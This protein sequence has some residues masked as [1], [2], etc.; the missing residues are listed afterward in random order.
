MT[1]DKKAMLKEVYHDTVKIVGGIL[2]GLFL[3]LS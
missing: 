3:G 2:L 1:D